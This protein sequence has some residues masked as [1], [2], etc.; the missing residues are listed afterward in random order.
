MSAKK[1][2]PADSAGNR[3]SNRQGGIQVIS[4]ATAIL[5]ALGGNPGGLSLAAIAQEV[6]LPRS[7]VQRIVNSLE[8]EGLAESVGA[9]GGF[10][11]G[12]EVGR[13]FY[14]AQVDIANTM[15]PLLQE[16][17]DRLQESVVI[18]VRA[19]DR[20]LVTDR[21]IAER[22]L[23]VV[24]PVG[25]IQAPLHATATGKALLAGMSDAEVEALLPDPLPGLEHNRSRQ[26][27]LA[28]LREI[29][30]SGMATD[31]DALIEGL[32]AFAVPVNTYL[33]VIA[34]GTFM[35]TSRAKQPLSTFR[36]ILLEYKARIEQ[37]VGARPVGG[38]EGA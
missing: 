19:Q 17:S 2:L 30:A 32:A 15:R 35:P 38:A 11:L 13:L 33:G 31:R 36:D 7:T 4:R 10:R 22:E 8:D 25:A 29:R 18:C 26:A 5:R 16:L 14:L 37:K 1:P 3:V 28:E 23:R 27:L 24:F 6:D 21:V 20:I 12:P 34:L 9:G